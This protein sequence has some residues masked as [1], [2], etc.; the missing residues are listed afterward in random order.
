MIENSV[1]DMW[2]FFFNTENKHT[3]LAKDKCLQISP[4]DHQSTQRYT[5]SDVL[6]SQV[7]SG[8]TEGHTETV[9]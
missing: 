3:N 9:P 4:Q 2:K 8:K 1:K 5:Q 6:T 7:H